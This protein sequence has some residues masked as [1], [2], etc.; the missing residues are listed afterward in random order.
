MA[1]RI[2]KT[3]LNDDWKKRI[4]ASQVMNR[5]Y[6]H[7]TGELELTSSQINA[8]K[9]ILSKMVPDLAR[10]EMTGKDGKDLIPTSVQIQL[11]R[12][13]ATPAS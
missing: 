13:D 12:P 7:I 5:L 9:I 11:V 1:A 3:K 10:T 6:S 8:A 2:R 4:Q